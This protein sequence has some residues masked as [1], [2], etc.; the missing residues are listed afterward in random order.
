MV[1]YGD[2][3]ASLAAKL[4]P[5]RQ[6]RWKALRK[7]VHDDSHKQPD[8]ICDRCLSTYQETVDCEF[9][10]KCELSTDIQIRKMA[11]QL[12]ALEENEVNRWWVYNDPISW[13]QFYLDWEPRWY[14]VE[15]LRCTGRKKVFRMGRQIGKCAC[16]DTH[17]DLADGTRQKVKDLDGQTVD[18]RSLQGTRIVSKKASVF[19]NAVKE[20]YRVTFSS[21]RQLTTSYDH[22]YRAFDRWINTEDLRVGDR[23]ASCGVGVFGNG[24]LPDEHAEL[25]AFAIGDG[26]L[27]GGSFKFTNTNP[28]IVRRMEELAESQ[29]CHLT[30]EDDITCSVV[31]QKGKPNPVTDMLREHGVFGHNAKTKFVPLAIQGANRR[32]VA[33]FL[34]RLFSNDGWASVSHLGQAQIGYCS[35]SHDLIRDVQ[36]MLFKFGIFSTISARK[37]PAERSP[38]Y[39]MGEFHGAFDTSSRPVPYYTSWQLFITRG[40]DI[41]KFANEIGILGK[42]SALTKAAIAS[43]EPANNERSIV[44]T[45]PEDIRTHVVRKLD[46][47]SA[48]SVLGDEA[49]VGRR[50]GL[51]RRVAL[52]WANKLQDQA[53]RAHAESDVIWD[54]VVS[55][56]CVGDLQTYDLSVLDAG[57][58]DDANFS[59]EGVFVHNTEIL[60][61]IALFSI[62]TRARFKV[63]ILCPYQDQVDLIF[64]RIRGFI[65][66]SGDLTDR[67]FKIQDKMNPHFIKYHHEGGDSSVIGITAGVR[68][69]QHADKARG[70]SPDM[71]IIDEADMLDDKSLESILAMLQGKGHNIAQ[72]VISSTPTGRRGLFYRWCTDKRADF[73]EFHFPSMVSPTWD[74]ETELFYRMSYSENGFAHEFLAEFGE[75]DAGL[76]QH[77]YIEASMADYSLSRGQPKAEEI[78]GFG[79]DWNRAG[80]G[81][82]IIVTGYNTLSGKFRTAYK[83]VVDPSE[84]TQHVAIHRINELAKVWKPEFV[85]ADS[86]D[87]DMQVEALQLFGQQHPETKLHRMAK[88]IDFGSKVVVKDPL[89]KGFVKKAVKPLMVD[90]CV[91]RVESMEC[92]FPR[93]EDTKTGLVG[94]MREYRVIKYGRDGQPTFTK[95]GEHTLVAWMLSV[96]GFIME[97][98]DL[99]KS[100]TVTRI[101]FTKPLGER[102][103]M[104]FE[105]D[106]MRELR[107]KRKRLTP[108]VRSAPF[109]MTPSQFGGTV[110]E[111]LNMQTRFKAGARGMRDAMRSKAGPRHIKRAT[112]DRGWPQASRYEE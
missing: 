55:I 86:G 1:D 18:V 78:Y 65:Q 8:Y 112:W 33:L 100:P 49:R 13:A 31:N 93:S 27:T 53:L 73:R 51:S 102:G 71:L 19:K 81:A 69:G 75:M 68:T 35:A 26:G 21:G 66:L 38:L 28:E 48:R 25:L 5:V 6:E 11:G 92:I 77:K 41:R 17:I 9:S 37:I 24:S 2:K 89:T 87:G 105:Q 67:G 110:S 109:S 46:G 12:A 82:H 63:V 60:A 62:T 84:F 20:C 88:G 104:I 74:E 57:C 59:A 111:F 58:Y 85:Y 108:A 83:E 45:L 56:E 14:Q 30:W 61:L 29:G 95:E 36:E 70:Q 98:S 34:N 90:L 32:T 40:E 80:T 54:R 10:P 42:G 72:M 47:R 16:P 44:D 23:I 7:E 101:A 64:E 94:Q 52:D 76:F 91:R 97:M 106:K 3:V 79:V 107:E 15:P 50:R 96:Y 4:K 39:R 103:M 99:A 22:P 43:R